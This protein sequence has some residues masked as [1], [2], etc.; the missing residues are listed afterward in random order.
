KQLADRIECLQVRHRVRPRGPADGRLV[1]E[2]RIGDQLGAF[3]F[4]ERPDALVPATFCSFHRRV[5]DV[6]DECGLARP[7]DTRDANQRVE[8][9]RDI[10]VAQ[11]VLACADQTY[12]LSRA[13]TSAGWNGNS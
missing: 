3:D 13:P 5:Q 12:P 9:Y 8:R 11:V 7:A 4:L 2:N 6:V 1:D 10:D